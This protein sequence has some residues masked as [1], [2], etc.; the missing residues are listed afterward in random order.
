VSVARTTAAAPDWESEAGRSEPVVTAPGPGAGAWSVAGRRGTR[1]AGDE[2]AEPGVV[3][4]AEDDPADQ[5]LT[6]R[7]F[8][9]GDGPDLRIVED[10]AAALDYLH[11][12]G[13]FA[14]P[15]ASPRPLLVI[16]DLNMPR[17]GGREVLRQMRRHPWQRS[18]PVVILTT[19]DQQ[20]DIA[21]AYALGANSYVTKPLGLRE[22]DRAVGALREYWFEIAQLPRAVHPA[23]REG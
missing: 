12:R 19:S 3:L 15:A 22:F 20:E 17:M 8:E 7:A 16:L 13:P 23:E 10:G 9:I 14:D 2:A 11:R 18:V 6:R 4:L 21:T 1:A 5:E